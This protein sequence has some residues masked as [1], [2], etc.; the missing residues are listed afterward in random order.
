M[1]CASLLLSVCEMELQ[2]VEFYHRTGS[3]DVLSFREEYSE[4]FKS[5]RSWKVLFQPTTDGCREVAEG[6]MQCHQVD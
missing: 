2:N 6:E 3:Q 4:L 1:L 5:G